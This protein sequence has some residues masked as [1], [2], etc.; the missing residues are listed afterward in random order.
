MFNKGN[1]C[2]FLSSCNAEDWCNSI[3]Q[4]KSTSLEATIRQRSFH[5]ALSNCRSQQIHVAVFYKFVSI[6]FD[7]MHLFDLSNVEVPVHQNIR[8]RILKNAIINLE[9]LGHQETEVN[10]MI[11][12]D[13]LK[14]IFINVDSQSCSLL[15]LSNNTEAE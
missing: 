10:Q 14:I 12:L 4:F 9:Y 3:K 15:L 5:C 1:V 2:G 7:N 6:N 8:N 11:Q 13:V